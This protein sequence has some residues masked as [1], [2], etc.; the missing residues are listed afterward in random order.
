VLAI[1][2]YGRV[3]LWGVAAAAPG[4][5][6][7]GIRFFAAADSGISRHNLELPLQGFLKAGLKRESDTTIQGGFAALKEDQLASVFVR[8][9]PPG[10][11]FEVYTEFGREDHSLDDR[12][13]ILEPDHSA[14]TNFGFR[15][16][17]LSPHVMH[18]IRGEVFTY[19][20]SPGSRTRAEGQNYIH[21]ILR[22]GHTER[23]QMLGANVGP[24]AG[25]AQFFAYDRFSA[26]G[27]WT[28]FVSREVQHELRFPNVYNRGPALPRAVDVQNSVGLEVT[29]FMGPFDVM[30]RATLTADLNRYFRADQSNANLAFGLR[31]N[32]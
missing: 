13:L 22:Q 20:A 8:W 1:G 16:A 9:A 27:G 11:G 24:G 7:G 31:Q 29:R 23:G 21:G 10:S 3:T 32:F 18:A 15:K 28:A 25:A 5:E 12:D 4:L 19:E 2:R 30:A 17:W 26:G 14:S 6:I